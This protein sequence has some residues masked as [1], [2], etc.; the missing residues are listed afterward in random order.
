MPG[1]GVKARTVRSI[2]A[3]VCVQSMCPSSF[4][5]RGASVT[6]ASSCGCGWIVAVEIAGQRL[7]QQV[8]AQFGE[9]V[10]ERLPGLV[11]RERDR[12]LAEDRSGI[13]S[14]VHL[15]DGDAGFG[16]SGADHG[17]NRSSA[18]PAREQRGMNVDRAVRRDVEHRLR[19]NLPEGGDDVDIGRPLLEFFDRFGAAKLLRLKD[20]NARRRAPP[21]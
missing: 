1:H 2:C 15:H 14:G 19:Q 21:A 8:A 17:L 20:R 12:A 4:W 7:D 18:A 9:L 3:A 6:S 11:G 13:Q 10:V 16:I 5:M